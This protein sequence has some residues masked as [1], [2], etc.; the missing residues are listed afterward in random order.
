MS[1]L[2]NGN[3]LGASAHE[4]LQKVA[5]I[6]GDSNSDPFQADPLTSGPARWTSNLYSRPELNVGFM[7]FRSTGAPGYVGAV[8]GFGSPGG[9]IKNCNPNEPLGDPDASYVNPFPGTLTHQRFT[10]DVANFSNLTYTGHFRTLVASRFGGVGTRIKVTNIFAATP[11]HV[12]EADGGNLKCQVNTDDDGTIGGATENNALR[13]NLTGVRSNGTTIPHGSVVILQ[14]PH[15]V[16]LQPSGTYHNVSSAIYQ[17][18]YNEADLPGALVNGT[19]ARWYTYI[20]K[21]DTGGNRLKNV[22]GYMYWGGGGYS[23]ADFTTDGRAGTFDGWTGTRLFPDSTATAIINAVQNDC[24]VIALGFNDG[25]AN[26]TDV[27]NYTTRLRSIINRLLAL[28]NVPVVLIDVWPVFFD[29]GTGGFLTQQAGY[30]GWNNDV[31]V[32]GPRYNF[33]QKVAV[34]R[35]MI[36]EFPSKVC[37]VPLGPQMIARFGAP[38]PF[39]VSGWYR[40]YIA[41][42]S[43][44]FIHS[45]EAGGALAAEIIVKAY[46]RGAG[47]GN[48]DTGLSLGLAIADH[49]Q[50]S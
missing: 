43:G 30:V 49:T 33:D 18:F 1:T 21:V 50:Q 5:I 9:T 3:V 31:T 10:S 28:R 32:G 34:N 42:E 11:N 29:G 15:D 16:L 7:A 27:T 35:Q 47:S 26:G 8:G 45:R 19:L 25:L 4:R 12:D 37:V 44:N 20:E 48:D 2:L 17:F 46:E 14:S 40:T 23:T 41:N 38:D 39:N 22:A 36:A 6:L 24:W 13:R